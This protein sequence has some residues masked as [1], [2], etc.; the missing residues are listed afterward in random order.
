LNPPQARGYNFNLV[1]GVIAEAREIATAIA[2][3]VTTLLHKAATLLY[4]IAILLHQTA[5][6]LY[7]VI[8]LLSQVAMYSYQ[9][10]LD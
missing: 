4:Q 3:L 8:L 2:A 1:R 10:K 6:F 7:R 9:Q 5:M